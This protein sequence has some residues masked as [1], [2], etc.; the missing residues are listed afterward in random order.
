[1]QAAGG[2]KQEVRGK[3]EGRGSRSTSEATGLVRLAER[4][5]RYIA[6]QCR[7]G[8][9]MEYLAPYY[10]QRAGIEDGQ[11][12]ATATSARSVTR[13]S[14]VESTELKNPAPPS[15]PYAKLAGVRHDHE[16]N[17]RQHTAIEVPLGAVPAAD[18][19]R[20]SPLC[21]LVRKAP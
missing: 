14:A 8:K 13:L 9:L 12:H 20:K 21:T 1:M 18:R 16:R 5:T 15:T 10:R 7:M 11:A 3:Q 4:A 6:L 17:G 19:R 2:K